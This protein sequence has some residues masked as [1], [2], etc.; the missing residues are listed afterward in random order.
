MWTSCAL[1]DPR[2]RPLVP[3]RDH[4][5]AARRGVEPQWRH[6]RL[7]PRRHALP[8]PGRRRLRPV[9][10]RPEH[11]LAARQGAPHPAR[12]GRRL[13]RP[14]GQ[15]VRQRRLVL[16]AAQPLPLLDRSR[17]WRPRHRRRGQVTTEEID[18]APASTSRGRGWNYGW[19]P[20]EGSYAQG[21]T[22][23]PC[24][25]AGAVG[26]VLDRF[27]PDWTTINAGVVVRDRSLPSL[28]GRFV[29]GDTNGGQLHSA[30]LRRPRVTD[31]RRLGFSL[32]GVAGFG[33][34]AAGCVYAASLNGGVHRFVETSTQVPARIPGAR[35]PYRAPD[36]LAHPPPPARSQ[37]PRRYRLR[38]L[39]RAQGF[40]QG[41]HDRHGQPAHRRQRQPVPH[42]G[43]HAPTLQPQ[44][45]LFGQVVEGLDVSAR[46]PTTAGRTAS[47]ESCTASCGSRSSRP[48]SAVHRPIVRL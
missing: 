23:T 1:R 6:G 9:R 39:Q 44:Y 48:S 26:P 27:Q 30:V 31:D 33:E 28:F 38:A 45:P 32:P 20:C 17:H 40:L 13:P 19:D 4:R 15:P 3:P 36:A 8:R 2:Q 16:R 5:D 35:R 12:A 41:G 43:E 47:P 24:P 10:Q 18:F 46:S 21:S 7:R 37:A 34:D 29:Y 11:G 14:R 25:L 22:S 42:H